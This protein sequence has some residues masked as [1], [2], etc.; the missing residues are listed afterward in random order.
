MKTRIKELAERLWEDIYDLEEANRGFVLDDAIRHLTLL[1]KE[2]YG[3]ALEE[4]SRYPKATFTAEHI[5][6]VI[7]AKANEL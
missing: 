3:D 5:E 2:T 6:R 4:F 1:A 7:R